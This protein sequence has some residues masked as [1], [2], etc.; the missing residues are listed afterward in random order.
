M[1]ALE[2]LRETAKARHLPALDKLASESSDEY[3][4]TAEQAGI[5]N[6][7]LDAS[8]M[9]EA[10]ANSQRSPFVPLTGVKVQG[11]YTITLL[12]HAP[13]TAAAEAFINFLLGPAGQRALR[14]DHF[15]VLSPARVSGRG[16]PPALRAVIR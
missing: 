14:A 15:V 4:E 10:D 13:H 8:F 12:R 16:V 9:Y 2:A 11:D 7:Q 3:S 6:G 1:L 5:Q